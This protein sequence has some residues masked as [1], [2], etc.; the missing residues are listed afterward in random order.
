LLNFLIFGSI[1]SYLFGSKINCFF[2]RLKYSFCAPFE[3]C[4]PGRHTTHTRIHKSYIWGT[5]QRMR[6]N[7]Y[8]M[9]ILLDFFITHNY[10]QQHPPPSNPPLGNCEFAYALKPFIR[11]YSSTAQQP[12]VGQG[13][14]V[15]EA[16]WSHSV[17][18]LWTS[19]Q[20]DAETSTWQHT[21]LTRDKHPGTRLYSNQYSQP[22]SG[23]TPML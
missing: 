11:F 7:C 5:A 2:I 3:L 9:H 18:H 21:S 22:T 19:D 23:R 6:Q 10:T 4:R 15:I 16:L 1:I 13:L 8:T 17:R 14:L 12:L 20:S